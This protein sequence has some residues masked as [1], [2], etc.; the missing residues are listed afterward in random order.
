MI[1]MRSADSSM[2]AAVLF[3]SVCPQCFQARVQRGYSRAVL[4]SFLEADHIIEAY[5]MSCDEFWAISPRERAA[6]FDLLAH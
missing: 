2:D 4:G 5:C 1:S 6:L 3:A